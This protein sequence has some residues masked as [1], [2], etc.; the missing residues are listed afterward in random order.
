MLRAFQ[1]PISSL[2]VEYQSRHYLNALPKR[3]SFIAAQVIVAEWLASHPSTRTLIRL[4]N[5]EGWNPR[6]E[7]SIG[8]PTNGEPGLLRTHALNASHGENAMETIGFALA[9]VMGATL[10]LIGA[11]GSIL[12]VPILVYCLSVPPIVARRDYSVL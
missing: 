11:G 3:L 2:L 6:L 12:T 7:T 4:Y 5:L 8:L 10:G 9:F 1:E